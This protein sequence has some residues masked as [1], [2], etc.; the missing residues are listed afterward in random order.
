MT[1]DSKRR[2]TIVELKA[3]LEDDE[4]WLQVLLLALAAAPG[5]RT[6]DR[7][8]YRRLLPA[9]PRHPRRQAGAARAAGSGRPLLDRA[10]RALPALRAGA[11]ERAG[12]DVHPG[13]VDAQ[14]EGDHRG[15][16]RPQRL[17]VDDLGDA[18][19]RQGSGTSAPSRFDAASP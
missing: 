3:L 19:H 15:A 9:Q 18:A 1:T 7:V 4:D 2:S 13:R 12:G 8:G 10:V 5:E 14:G 6:R 16:V 11:G 17:G